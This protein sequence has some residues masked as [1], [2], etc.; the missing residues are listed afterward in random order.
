MTKRVR[1]YFISEIEVA[2]RALEV[3]APIK[4]MPSGDSKVDAAAE[5]AKGI[6]QEIAL[7]II[8]TGLA[9]IR[10]EHDTANGEGGG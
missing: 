7:A 5:R 3:L 9:E 4:V 1:S 6:S 10:E 2:C 8:R